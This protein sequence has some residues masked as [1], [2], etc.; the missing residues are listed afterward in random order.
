MNIGIQTGYR[1]KIAVSMS[2]GCEKFEYFSKRKKF[3]IQVNRHALYLR[4]T[5]IFHLLTYFLY[6]L[7]FFSV[8]SVPKS[9]NDAVADPRSAGFC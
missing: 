3:K 9:F 1:L 6:F 5:T 7:F 8:I 4:R 2:N